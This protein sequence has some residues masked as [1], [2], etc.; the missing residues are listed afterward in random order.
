LVPDVKVVRPVTESA[1][2]LPAVRAKASV[3]RKMY[4]L[5]LISFQSILDNPYAQLFSSQ[6]ISSQVEDGFGSSPPPPPPPQALII[7]G[8]SNSK[9][10]TQR[11]MDSPSQEQKLSRK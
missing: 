3:R 10:P 4:F 8:I 9:T 2:T 11:F 6:F 5:I 1:Q 7:R